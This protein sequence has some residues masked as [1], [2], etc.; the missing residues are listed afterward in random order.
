MSFFTIISF[1]LNLFNKVHPGLPGVLRHSV[2]LWTNPRI[3]GWGSVSSRTQN[4]YSNLVGM[5]TLP[6]HWVI[7]KLVLVLVFGVGVSFSFNFYP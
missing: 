5:M 1:Y 3:H 2:K 4:N 6:T 7:S